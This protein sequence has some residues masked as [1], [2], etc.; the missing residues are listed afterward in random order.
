[1][2]RPVVTHAVSR[3]KRPL[4][5]KPSFDN[6]KPFIYA[7]VAG[8]LASEPANAGL[9]EINYT[10]PFMWTVFTFWMY[11]LDKNIVTPNAK[12]L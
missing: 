2:A 7:G 9:L 3:S 5:T 1:M 10:L 8:L 4:F 11:W 6:V 12:Y